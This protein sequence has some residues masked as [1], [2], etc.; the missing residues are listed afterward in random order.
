[1]RGKGNL[2]YYSDAEKDQEIV[3]QVSSQ[4]NKVMVWQTRGQDI[5]HQWMYRHPWWPFWRISTFGDYSSAAEL[6]GFLKDQHSNYRNSIVNG[7]FKMKNTTKH[8]CEISCSSSITCYPVFMPYPPK[9]I[10]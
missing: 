2:S 7:D 3:D 9:K 10:K 8:Q 1:L 5:T 4:L 6:S